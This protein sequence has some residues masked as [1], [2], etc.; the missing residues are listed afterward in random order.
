MEPGHDFHYVRVTLSDP[1]VVEQRV[2]TS[3]HGDAYVATWP[4]SILASW[5]AWGGFATLICWGVAV[6]AVAR[7]YRRDGDV[8]NEETSHE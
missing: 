4:D 6:A 7:A 3:G 2:T 5:L 8:H 1:I